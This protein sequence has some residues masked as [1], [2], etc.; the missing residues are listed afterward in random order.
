MVRL[1]GAFDQGRA[2]LVGEAAFDPEAVTAGDGRSDLSLD[3]LRGAFPCAGR[4]PSA[5]AVGDNVLVEVALG[6]PVAV[7]ALPRA[8][9]GAVAAHDDGETGRLSSW[10]AIAICSTGAT[11]GRK[12]PA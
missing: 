7:R 8:L 3:E 9:A 6:Q 5:D 11:V 2:G 12:C 1:H 10:S 4:F